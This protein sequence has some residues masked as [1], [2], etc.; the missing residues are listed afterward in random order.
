[1]SHFHRNDGI[2]GEW[3]RCFDKTTREAKVGR[4]SRKTLARVAIQNFS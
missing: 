1:M 4:V 2:N 3:L